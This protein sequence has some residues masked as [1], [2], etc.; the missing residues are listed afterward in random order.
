M[1]ELAS[2]TLRDGGF[3]LFRD[4]SQACKDVFGRS[5]PNIIDIRPETDLNFL[6]LR[7]GT[8]HILR[9]LAVKDLQQRSLRVGT[10]A[11]ILNLGEI[12]NRIGRRVLRDR[13]S[14]D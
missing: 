11:A 10:Q 8:Q 13:C 6:K 14:R 2:R 12:K 1:V 7:K 5:A 3:G 4:G 9:K